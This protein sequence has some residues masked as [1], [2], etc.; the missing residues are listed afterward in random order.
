MS[1]KVVFGIVEFS[2]PLFCSADALGK[3]VDVTIGT[4]AGTLIL[5]SFPDWGAEDASALNK[6]LVAPGEVREW[7]RGKYPPSWG[8]TVRYPSG[9][10]LVNLA[11][12][13]MDLCRDNFESASQEVYK[14][15]PVWVALFDQYVTLLTTKKS[16][17]DVSDEPGNLELLTYEE[18]QFTYIPTMH[19]SDMNFY[20]DGPDKFLRFEQFEEAASLSSKNLF[21]RLEYKMLLQAYRAREEEDYRKA[22]VEAG[23]ALEISLTHRIVEEFRNQ[24]ISFGQELLNKKYR[25]LGGM[26]ELVRLLG[27]QLPNTEQHYRT[28]V[29]EPRNNVVHKAEFPLRPTADRFITEVEGILRLFSPV[30][31]E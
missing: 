27:I 6:H 2:S 4:Q 13:K 31:Y 23:S 1:K 22:I 12:L 18:G 7:R 14:C 25:M 5:P 26:F 10:S 9:E 29:I 21:P 28:F 16:C 24:S 20:L 15:F 11:L 8:Q 30:I 17:Q 3:T 19:C